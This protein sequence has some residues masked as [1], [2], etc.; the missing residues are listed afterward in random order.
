MKKINEFEKAQ[1]C[2]Q[3]SLV[4]DGGISVADG[5]EAMLGQIEDAEY[6]KALTHVKEDMESGKTFSE[7]LKETNLYDSYFIHMVEVGENSGYLDKVFKEMSLYYRRMDDT[8]HKVK[9]ALTYPSI[10]VTMML[11]VIIV[12]L[13]KILPIFR[14]VLNNM[15]I[16][17]SSVS[18]TLFDIGRNFAIISLVVLVVLFAIVMFIFMNLKVSGKSFTTVLEKFPFTNK[19]SYNL[20]V[21]QFAYALSLLMD[22]GYAQEKALEMCIEMCENKQLKDKITT[23]LTRLNTG[24]TLKDCLLESHIFKETY[25]R[26]L[27]IGLQSGHFET[28]LARIAQAYEEEIDYSI[29]K[30][31]D[32]IEPSLVALLSLIVGVILL[33]VM[34]PLTGIM[35]SL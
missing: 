22:S 10:L 2:E 33:S 17:L 31:L 20:A 9:D 11:V 26:L 27:V 13:W 34:L 25:N 18:S 15:G 28:T 12:L 3:M 30:I 16:Q 19:L 4:L 5:L 6:K 24:D 1:F 7:A 23:I 8:F 14:S 29:N 21:V 32:T 35:A